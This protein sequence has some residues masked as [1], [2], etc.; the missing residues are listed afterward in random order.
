MFNPVPPATDQPQPAHAEPDLEPI[1]ALTAWRPRGRWPALLRLSWLCRLLALV[2]V[3]A[4]AFW[5]LMGLTVA[6]LGAEQGAIGLLF[7]IGALFSAAVSYITWMG[8]AELI[9]LVIALERNTRQ[10]R[11]RLP[12]HAVDVAEAVEAR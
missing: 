2:S 9:L 10:T 3:V 12:R 6:L 7:I 4:C 11:D 5:A 8:L 1:P